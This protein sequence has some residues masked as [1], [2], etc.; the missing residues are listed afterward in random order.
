MVVRCLKPKKYFYY[1]YISLLIPRRSG[2]KPFI[3]PFIAYTLTATSMFSAHGT[4]PFY[5]SFILCDNYSV[6]YISWKTWFMN[7]I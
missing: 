1:G 6:I 4:K 5:T 3:T 2:T 7:S